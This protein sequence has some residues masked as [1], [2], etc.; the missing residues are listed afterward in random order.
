M[1]LLFCT[2]KKSNYV[3]LIKMLANLYLRL[4]IQG[5]KLWKESSKWEGNQDNLRHVLK[6]YQLLIL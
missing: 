3:Q 6:V 4:L 1:V 5:V 2:I